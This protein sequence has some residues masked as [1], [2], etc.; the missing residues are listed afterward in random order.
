MY[1]KEIRLN[2][3]R[4]FDSPEIELWKSYIAGD[5]LLDEK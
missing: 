2:A 5:F 1:M 4:V 3:C